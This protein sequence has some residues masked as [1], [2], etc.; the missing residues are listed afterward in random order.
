ME[1]SLEINIL[2]CKKEK[3]K[4]NK[5]NKASLINFNQYQLNTV[6]HFIKL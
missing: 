4:K 2:R 6:D 1:R 3:E 5:V